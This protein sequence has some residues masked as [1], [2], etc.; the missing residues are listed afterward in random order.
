MGAVIGVVFGY[1][2]GTRAGKEGWAQVQDA[3]GTITSSDE[4]RDLVT[5]GLTMARD[6]AGR[7]GGILGEALGNAERGGLLRSAA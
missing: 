2:L 1:M 7:S 4:V 5:T 3:W 6:M